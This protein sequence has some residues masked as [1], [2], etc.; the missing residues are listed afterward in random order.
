M[1]L[2]NPEFWP[3]LGKP[4]SWPYG[5]SEVLIVPNL[6]PIWTIQG[7]SHFWTVSVSVTSRQSRVSAP[8]RHPRSQPCPV[9]GLNPDWAVLSL[10]IVRAVLDPGNVQA[11]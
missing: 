7:P 3:Y 8:S 11:V 9:V 4:R 2:N 1:L 6:D 5:Q 10:N